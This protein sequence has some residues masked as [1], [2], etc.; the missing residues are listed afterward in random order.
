MQVI[1]FYF[2]LIEKSAFIYQDYILKIKQKNMSIRSLL[3]DDG[4]IYLFPSLQTGVQVVAGGPGGAR[5]DTGG[6][7]RVYSGF[8]RL[9]S[10]LVSN[11]C[12][13]A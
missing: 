4:R 8:C 11:W 9:Q 5:V 7:C 13:Y 2:L 3:V 6:C 12:C 10:A 1:K